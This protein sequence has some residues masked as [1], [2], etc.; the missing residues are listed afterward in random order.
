MNEDVL[1]H[2][3]V[4]KPQ[5]QVRSKVHH[6]LREAIIQGNLRPG[7]RLV[8]RK[9]AAQLRV[10]RTPV[11]EAI[12]VLEREGLVS[13][14][15]RVGAVVAE[16][17]SQDVLDVYRI[18]AV[19]EGLAARL[20]AER[21]GEDQLEELNSLLRQVNRFARTGEHDRMETAH[22]EFND[23]L[24]RAAGSRRLYRMI[25]TL[26]DYIGVHVRIGYSR[27][28][29]VAE[30]EGEHRRL[31]EAIKMRDGDL[32]ESTARAHI[33]N[34]RRAYFRTISEAGEGD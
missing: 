1:L 28:G 8:E 2:P 29:R 16:V 27:P 14:I 9:L 17:D 4:D 10:S 18:R 19:L 33:E 5:S 21:I 20:A 7:D 30:A 26:V 3:I 6:R 32:A 11:R 22:R 15:P 23:V 13:H 12:R 34:S 24:Y 25:T 31:V